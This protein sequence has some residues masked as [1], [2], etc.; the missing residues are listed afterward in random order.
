MERHGNGKF[1]AG[2][3]LGGKLPP[4]Q[5]NVDD[6]SKRSNDSAGIKDGLS[7]LRSFNSEDC[8]PEMS[9]ARDPFTGNPLQRI[10]ENPKKTSASKRG[11]NFEIC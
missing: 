4:E 3:E 6:T 2:S 9:N 11:K 5:H 10:S 8:D 1:G 7:A